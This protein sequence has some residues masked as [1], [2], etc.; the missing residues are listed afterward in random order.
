[1][2]KVVVGMLGFGT[3]GTGVIRLL[4]DTPGITLKR[5]AVRDLNKKRA[6]KAPCAV[7]NNPM[8]L[9]DD[10]EI[11]V[12]IEVMGGGSSQRSNSYAAQLKSVNI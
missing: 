9:V 10:P 7:T 12:I 2:A 3:V 1:M 11:E 5:V 4:A 6:V 8:E